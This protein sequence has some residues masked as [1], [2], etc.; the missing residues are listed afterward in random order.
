ML[1]SSAALPDLGFN[2]RQ[3]IGLS[4][5]LNEFSESSECV[6]TRSAAWGRRC[7]TRRRRANWQQRSG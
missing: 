6:G 5:A 2:Q 1:R 7:S 3:I 4:A